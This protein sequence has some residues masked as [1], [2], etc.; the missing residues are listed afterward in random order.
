MYYCFHFQPLSEKPISAPFKLD[1]LD[2]WSSAACL[3]L[4]D[5][6]KKAPVYFPGHIDSMVYREVNVYPAVLLH[7]INFIL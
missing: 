3:S 4:L 1:S 5:A 7:L 2:S 6:S